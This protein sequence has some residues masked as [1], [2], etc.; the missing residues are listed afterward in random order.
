M[1]PMSAAG[2]SGWSRGR[3]P[4]LYVANPRRLWPKVGHAKLIIRTTANLHP[5][6]THHRDAGC[7]WLQLGCYCNDHVEQ[8]A[9]ASARQEARVASLRIIGFVHDEAAGGQRVMRWQNTSERCRHSREPSG[10]SLR[11]RRRA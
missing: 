5:T 1:A 2:S 4:V 9:L 6:T 11:S 7:V 10:R 8:E 3:L